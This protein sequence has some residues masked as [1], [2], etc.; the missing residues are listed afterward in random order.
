MRGDKGPHSTGP[1]PV[2]AAAAGGTAGPSE[3]AAGAR[4]V[5]QGGAGGTPGDAG[6][7]REAVRAADRWGGTGGPTGWPLP[8]GTGRSGS[9]RPV[10]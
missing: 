4:A 5:R 6:R 8:D 10:E 2:A 3:R 1:V 7:A 9:R